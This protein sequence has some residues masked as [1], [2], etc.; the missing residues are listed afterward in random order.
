MKEIVILAGI[1]A[2]LYLSMELQPAVLD[3]FNPVV[4]IPV[5]RLLFKEKW[6]CDIP[7]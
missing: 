4:A 7:Q 1:A 3:V 6:V 2:I 5:D